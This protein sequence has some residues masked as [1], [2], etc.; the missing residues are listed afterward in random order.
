MPEPSGEDVGVEQDRR[1]A[2]SCSAREGFQL[3]V[4]GVRDD[5]RLVGRQWLGADDLSVD[6]RGCQKAALAR[7]IASAPAVGSVVMTTS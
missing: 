4:G 3:V 5:E 6:P 7:S 2:H 1:D